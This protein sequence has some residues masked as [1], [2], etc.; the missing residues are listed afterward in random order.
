M[1]CGSTVDTTDAAITGSP[2]LRANTP[3]RSF[4]PGPD[5]CWN[6]LPQ[7][8]QYRLISG[9]SEEQ[10]AQII[11]TLLR[12]RRPIRP[13]TGSCARLV[14]QR[15]IALGGGAIRIVAYC[16]DGVTKAEIER[17]SVDTPT[18]WWPP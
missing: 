6:E 2:G 12:Q 15:T 8:Q 14:H 1:L 5:D 10:L 17:V 11:D 3:D 9:L 7:A 16:P 13:R 4:P 18:H